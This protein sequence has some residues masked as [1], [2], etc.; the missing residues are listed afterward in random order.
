MLYPSEW[1]E[2][3]IKNSAFAD[4]S[5]KH[6]CI[7][8]GLGKDACMRE[9]V[10]EFREYVGSGGEENENKKHFKETFVTLAVSSSEC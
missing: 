4:V 7:N 2:T 10:D 5:I 3:N 1:T 6:T 9:Y 8:L